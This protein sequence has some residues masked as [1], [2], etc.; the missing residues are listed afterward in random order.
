MKKFNFKLSL[1]TA[2]FLMCFELSAQN[3]IDI[4]KVASSYETESKVK[5]F[6]N[7]QPHDFKLFTFNSFEF[8]TLLATAPQRF[9][10]QS[11]TII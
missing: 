1:L 8:N 10:A 2:I 3:S 6:R 9:T 11:N 4:W 7:T 5:V